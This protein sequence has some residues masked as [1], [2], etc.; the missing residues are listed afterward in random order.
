MIS[1]IKDNYK[2][3]YRVNLLKQINL[4]NSLTDEEL[5]TILKKIIIKNFKKGQII[6][7]EE[8]TNEFMYIILFGVVKVVRLTEDGKEIILAVHRSGDFF[9]EISIIDKKTLPATVVAMEDSSIAKI[10]EGDFLALI[11]E[12]EKV[13]DNLLRI[14]CSRLRENWER[15]QILSFN[16]AEQR[17]KTLFLKYANESGTKCPEGAILHLKLTHQDLANMIGISRETVTRI[18][19]KWRTDGEI[20]IFKDR[21]ILLTNKF[22]QIL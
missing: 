20:K 16:N 5:S 14:F 15:I 11:H 1:T 4:F 7:H 6:L 19:D 12:Y 8:D 9:G 22:L 3:D 17:I 10:N 2:L 18:I 13:L 21:R